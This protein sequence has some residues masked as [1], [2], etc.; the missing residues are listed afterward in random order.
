[1]NGSALL[2]ILNSGVGYSRFLG[3][4]TL[5]PQRHAESRLQ[6][7]HG[8]QRQLE[9]GRQ[10]SRHELWRL[11][12]R[13]RQRRPGV[14]ETPAA[15]GLTSIPAQT[16]TFT[17]STGVLTLAASAPPLLARR[18]QRDG[19]VDGTDLN[20]VLSNYGMTSGATWAMGDFNGDGAVNGTDLNIVL[21]NYGYELP[22]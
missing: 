9:L 22:A 7:R 2:A 6:R 12:R 4:G 13:R 16:W 8:D 11:V 5:E 15:Y 10:Q 20:I 3:T 14:Y 21:S 19:K 1:M 17:Q 18:R